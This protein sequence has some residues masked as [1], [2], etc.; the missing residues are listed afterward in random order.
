NAAKLGIRIIPVASSGVDTDTEFLCRCMAMAT[1]GTYTFLTDDSG[2]GYSHLEPTIG[3]YE[4]EKLNDMLVRIITDYFSQGARSTAQDSVYPS[5]ESEPETV[6]GRFPAAY[7]YTHDYFGGEGYYTT[8]IIRSEE[9]LAA[10][11]EK[12]GFDFEGYAEGLDFRTSALAYKVD[13]FGSGSISIDNS[14]GVYATVENG[15]PVFHYELDI[16][17]VGTADIV[18][19]FLYSEITAGLLQ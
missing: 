1:G 14:K 11:E 3:N 19:V 5:N 4:V 18:S 10:F 2:V 12:Y 17:E 7:T 6:G 9:D 15:E 8:G 13:M 16:P